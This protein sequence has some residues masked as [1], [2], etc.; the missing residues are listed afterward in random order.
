MSSSLPPSEGQATSLHNIILLTEK[1]R[2]LA[3]A[4]E[5]F[6]ADVFERTLLFVWGTR[7]FLWMIEIST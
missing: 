4:S 7:Q 1:Q 3:A 2:V 5:N 6:K